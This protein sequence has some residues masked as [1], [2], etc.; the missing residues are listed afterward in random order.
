MRQQLS[1][2]IWQVFNNLDWHEPTNQQPD[3]NVS[4]ECAYLT[5]NH[6]SVVVCSFLVGVRWEK[7]SWT[8]QKSIDEFFV[9][10]VV[11]LDVY[12][13]V[14]FLALGFLLQYPR[15][16][17]VVNAGVRNTMLSVSS[18]VCN[19]QYLQHFKN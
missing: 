16:V 10:N 2:L 6:N 18:T 1:C 12:K 3:R 11:V 19:M 15:K 14:S 7:A 17:S 8:D 13:F 5:T 4:F 9:R